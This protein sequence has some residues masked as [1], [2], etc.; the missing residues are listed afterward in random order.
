MNDFSLYMLIFAGFLLGLIFKDLLKQYGAGEKFSDSYLSFLVL[1]FMVF[2]GYVLVRFFYFL[3]L[4]TF[5]DLSAAGT[6]STS[7]LLWLAAASLVGGVVRFGFDMLMHKRKHNVE[8]KVETLKKEIFDTTNNYGKYAKLLYGLASIVIYLCIAVGVIVAL[9]VGNFNVAGFY[10]GCGV[11]IGGA[12]FLS[13]FLI[14]FIGKNKTY[15]NTKKL[16]FVIGISILIVPT[17]LVFLL[18]FNTLWTTVFGLF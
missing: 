10:A 18:L 5:N 16:I 11:A 9:L 15:T 7:I 13:S 8:H 3:Q 1:P 2:V 14:N 17:I 12:M 6:F 4:P